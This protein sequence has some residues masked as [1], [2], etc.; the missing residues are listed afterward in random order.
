MLRVD[1]L[2]LPESSALYLSNLLLEG[3]EEPLPQ[4]ICKD[5]ALFLLA[6]QLIGKLFTLSL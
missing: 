5:L 6:F 2:D 3:L 1:F 4:L